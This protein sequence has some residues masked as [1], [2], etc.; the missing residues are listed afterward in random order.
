M[1]KANSAYTIE[2]NDL[3]Y[4][5]GVEKLFGSLDY[6]TMV[7]LNDGTIHNAEFT[8]IAEEDNWSM[9]YAFTQDGK[10][11]YVKCDRDNSRILYSVNNGKIDWENGTDVTTDSRYAIENIACNIVDVQAKYPDEAFT[12]ITADGELL[13][14]G[15][16]AMHM[17]DEAYTFNYNFV[18]VDSLV[19]EYI[20]IKNGRLVTLYS[21]SDSEMGYSSSVFHADV[22]ERWSNIEYVYAD[23][24]ALIAVSSYGKIYVDSGDSYGFDNSRYDDAENWSEKVV[25]IEGMV[26][27]EWGKCAYLLGVT[28]DGNVLISGILPDEA[29]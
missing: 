7:L 6:G 16:N 11:R 22:Y 19:N 12:A 5:S 8:H 21:V 10:W 26:D 25:F 14:Y 20:G 28:E 18:G 27:Y 17:N 15:F 9:D 23:S 13:V 4:L 24:S 2:K 3:R 29:A 1:K